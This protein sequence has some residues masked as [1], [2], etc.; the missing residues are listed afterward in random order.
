MSEFTPAADTG[1]LGWVTLPD[2][3]LGYRYDG[4]DELIVPGEM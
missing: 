1:Q 4:T 3:R 2:G